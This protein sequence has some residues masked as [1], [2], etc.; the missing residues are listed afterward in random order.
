MNNEKEGERKS[1]TFRLIHIDSHRLPRK[2]YLYIYS[3]FL[4]SILQSPAHFSKKSWYRHCLLLASVLIPLYK[5][6]YTQKYKEFLAS[7][8]TTFL[9]ALGTL[10]SNALRS[11]EKR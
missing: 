7:R 1:Q 8:T 2:N 5:P 9:L 10:R 3:T 6:I 11:R 4:S